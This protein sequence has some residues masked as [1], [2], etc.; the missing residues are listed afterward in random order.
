MSWAAKKFETVQDAYN[1]VNKQFAQEQQI[2]YTSDEI[3][4][5]DPIMKQAFDIADENARLDDIYPEYKGDT[6]RII[7]PVE[8]KQ[9]QFEIVQETNPMQDD[10]HV[11]IRSVD[12]IKT[13]AETINDEES[14]VWGDYSR[15]DAKRDLA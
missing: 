15:E 7:D 2:E 1:A 10:Y 12:D 3:Q 9:A 13:F 6:I 5:Q 4:Y 8:L 14:F 11:G